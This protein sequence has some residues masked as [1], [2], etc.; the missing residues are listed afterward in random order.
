MRTV[1]IPK[2]KILIFNIVYLSV[3]LSNLLNSCPILAKEEN[4]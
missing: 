4:H 3:M 1:K 2:A